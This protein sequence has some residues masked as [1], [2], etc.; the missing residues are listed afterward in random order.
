MWRTFP[1]LAASL[2]PLAILLACASAGSGAHEPNVITAPE[3]SRSGAA[4][5]YSA[6][7][8]LRPEVFRERVSGSV[9]YFTERRPM[10]AVGN[11]LAGGVEVLRAIPADQVARV[12]YLSAWQA[13]RR[14]GIG[15]TSGLVLVTK[16]S[17]SA[18]DLSSR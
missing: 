5:L 6:I 17:A 7:R 10:V 15:S 11:E 2:S 18:G 12:E 8:R 9:L 1:R 13:G 14:Y 16:Q 4:D 3:L